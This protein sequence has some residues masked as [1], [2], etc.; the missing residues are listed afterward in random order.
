MVRCRSGFAWCR[1]QTCWPEPTP[2]GLPVGWRPAGNNSI[3]VGW[4]SLPVNWVEDRF[5]EPSPESRVSARGRECQFADWEGSRSRSPKSPV[6]IQSRL[7]NPER[8]LKRGQRLR[9]DECYGAHPA[10]HGSGVTGSK[11]CFVPTRSQIATACLHKAQVAKG[12][13]RN[14]QLAYQSHKLLCDC[15]KAGRARL[16][17]RQAPVGLRRGSLPRTG[18]ERDARVRGNRAGQHLSGTQTAGGMSASAWRATCAGTRER[19]PLHT[20]MHLISSGRPTCTDRTA[21]ALN[22]V[23]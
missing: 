12:S 3:R 11:C 21:P 1:A 4:R 13:G 19:G 5:T 20:V 16:R 7:P 15:S 10:R 14:L 18:Q 8:L 17:R 9:T 23:A 6:R 22:V 2:G